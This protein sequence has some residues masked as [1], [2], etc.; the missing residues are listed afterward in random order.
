MHEG[1]TKIVL[2]THDIGQA[3]RLA[4][5]VI[6]LHHGRVV[7]HCRAAQFFASARSEAARAF[8]DGRIVT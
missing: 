4:D 3:R 5:D 1:R 8:L 7:E 2:V 6:F